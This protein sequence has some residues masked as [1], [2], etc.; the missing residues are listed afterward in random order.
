MRNILTIILLLIEITDAFSQ[1]VI[2]GK[3]HNSFSCSLTI[4]SDSTY[5]YFYHFDLSSSWSAGKWRNSNDTIYF[6]NIPIY[7]TVYYVDTFNQ[8]II[9]C[10]KKLLLSADNKPEVITSNE[11]IFLEIASLGQNRFPNPQKLYFK[12]GKLFEIKNNGQIVRKR[13]KGF[14]SHKKYPTYYERE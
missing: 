14:Y 7:D 9:K 2:V 13:I 4:N 3:Y 11:A 8:N 10:E 1:N 6:V 5:Y 12:N